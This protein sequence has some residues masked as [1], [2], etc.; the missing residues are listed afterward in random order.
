ML[1]AFKAWMDTWASGTGAY[2]LNKV[3]PA[4]LILAV[5]LIVIRI[6]LT[7]IN[8]TLTKSPLEKAAVS[9]IRSV[10][11]IVLYLLLILILASSLGIDVTGI[12]ALASVLTLAVSL[13]LQ[14]ALTNLIGGFTLLS[15]KPFRSED[16]VE[17]AGQSGTVKE[18]GLTYTKLLTADGKIVSIPNK[19]VVNAEILNYTAAG[20][21][22]VDINIGVSYNCK[23]D[24]VMAVLKLAA[25]CPTILPDREPY[26]AVSGYGESTINYVLQ[27]WTTAD[28]YWPTLHTI[29]RSIQSLFEQHQ[30]QFSYPHLNIHVD[31]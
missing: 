26:T 20:I 15:T 11:R 19:S 9:L 30:I 10:I 2:I 28:N 12:V 21:R 24:D 4:L 31:K 25:N 29:N 22:R 8:K 18:I 27:V 13:A 3:L 16:F 1:D 7:I 5:G 23:V 17:I 14:D 6:L